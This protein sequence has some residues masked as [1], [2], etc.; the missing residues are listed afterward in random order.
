MRCFNLTLKGFC[1]ETHAADVLVKWVLA[2]DLDALNAW[3]EQVGLRGHLHEEP[4]DMGNYAA[5]YTFGD[6][7]DVKVFKSG[8]CLWSKGQSLELWLRQ[9]KEAQ[10]RKWYM[11]H[12]RCS[13]CGTEW[14]DEWDCMCDD[15]CPRCNAEIEP[16]ASEEVEVTG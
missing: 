12:Y 16:Y 4:H 15:R 14:D 1:G 8:K 2:S 3:I 7:V 13:E 11:N 6:G 5:K 9:S 10:E